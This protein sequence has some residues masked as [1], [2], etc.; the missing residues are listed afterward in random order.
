MLLNDIYGKWI[1]R[2][3]LVAGVMTGTSVDAADIAFARFAPRGDNPP[4]MDIEGAAEIPFPKKLRE[5][6]FAVINQKAS[7]AVASRIHFELAHFFARAIKEA[8]DCNNINM[9]EIDAA[10]VHGQTVWHASNDR[11]GHSLQLFS[12]PVLCSLL[13][14]PVAYDFRA[15]D[16]AHG[17][18]GAPLSPVFDRDYLARGDGNIVALNIGGMANITIITNEKRIYAFDTG[19]GNVLIDQIAKDHFG[20]DCDNEGEIA[21]SGNVADPLFELLKKDEFII[22]SG[23]KST[24]REYY[25]SEY[26][27]RKLEDSATGDSSPRDIL[28][29]FTEF[30]AWSIAKAINGFAPRT[31][32]IFAAGGGLRNKFL[33]RLIDDYTN[34]EIFS[35][36][37]AGI[38]PDHREAL[39]FA[40]LGWLRLA[41]RPGNITAV[42]GAERQTL[43]GA[44]AF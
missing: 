7:I 32:K 12:G 35:T 3:R 11:P 14:I 39:C 10:G 37:A 5:N 31:E 17:G 16:I 42:T 34:A 28:R 22:A 44:V 18:Q 25:N 38:P 21:R 15:A 9:E 40:Y 24:G 19:P 13:D 43:L 4:A 23:P 6:I 41:G 1:S 2:P 36:A 29:T 30:S 8:A 27:K 26:I 33:M 20:S